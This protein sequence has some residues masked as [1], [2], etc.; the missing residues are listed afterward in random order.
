MRR[1]DLS[2]ERP[3]GRP[4]GGREQRKRYLIVCEGKDTEP[5]YFK[6]VRSAIR[7]S[8]LEIRIE[9][10]VGNPLTLVQYAISRRKQASLQART[11]RDEN[12]A[13]D[14]VWAVTD[15]DSHPHLDEAARIA[16]RAGI[17]LAVSNPCFEL[18]GLLHLAGH[19]ASVDNKTAEKLLRREMPT[20]VKV[21]DHDL[22]KGK[23]STA[24]DRAIKLTGNHAQNGSPED[25]NPSTNVHVLVDALIAEARR[26][27]A[28]SGR[29]ET[30]GL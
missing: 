8:M 13:F 23:Y 9:P 3:L 7:D 14:V 11:K 30:F 6:Y 25:A 20:Y 2:P 1:R 21:F 18:W 22:L 28:T 5:E 19:T 15:V 4:Q 10:S 29:S 12:L 17:G 16:S 26:F 27:V 24:R